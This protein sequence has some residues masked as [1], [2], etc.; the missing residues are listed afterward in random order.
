MAKQESLDRAY[1]GCAALIGE[2]SHAV[3]KKVGCIIVS[4]KGN[5]II[6]EGFNG[7]PSGFD[8]CCEIFVAHDYQDSDGS[9]KI[10][11]K[12]F[13]SWQLND[14]ICYSKTKDEVIHAEANALAKIARSNNSSEGATLYCTLM[15]CFE[16][17]K[18]I[19]Q[20]GIKRVVYL[21]H[22]PYPGHTGIVRTPGLELLLKAQ[23]QVD[24][25][26]D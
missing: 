5:H 26:T 7:T 11:T 24:K 8:N 15:P 25:L 10:C 13:R 9:H 20:A 12:C 14:I 22:Y 18:Q 16:C 3:R 4:A 21:E 23:I 19:I 2:L 6:A 1:I 17:A